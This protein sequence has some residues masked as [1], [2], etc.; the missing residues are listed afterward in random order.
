MSHYHDGARSGYRDGQGRASVYVIGEEVLLSY[1]A[2]HEAAQAAWTYSNVCAWENG[3]R[4]GYRLAA[5]GSP[6]PEGES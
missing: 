3:Y 1:D 6:L 2:A 4:Y 5:E